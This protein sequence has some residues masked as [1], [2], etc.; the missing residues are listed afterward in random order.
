[1]FFVDLRYKEMKIIF[2]KD[3]FAIVSFLGL[4]FLCG[5]EAE[6]NLHYAFQNCLLDLK[7]S[8]VEALL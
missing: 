6:Y 5:H 8:D 2:F 7:F 4:E 1:M 3:T